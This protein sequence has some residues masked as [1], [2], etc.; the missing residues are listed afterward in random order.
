MRS[1]PNETLNYNYF[2]D[3]CPAKVYTQVKWCN[4]DNN[5]HCWSF[6]FENKR[7]DQ[8]KSTNDNIYFYILNSS[9]HQPWSCSWISDPRRESEAMSVRE[10]KEM[11]ACRGAAGGGTEEVLE[12][13]MGGKRWQ[14][15]N[16][17]SRSKVRGNGGEKSGEVDK[18]HERGRRKRR[19]W[20]G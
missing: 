16:G 17:Q 14:D 15:C 11:H 7:T 10:G 18:Q 5:R 13:G 9:V 3:T 2:K 20:V 8:S 12:W 19:T 6:W 4:N 1:H